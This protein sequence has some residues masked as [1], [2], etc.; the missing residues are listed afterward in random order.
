M[1]FIIMAQGH[2]RWAA[3]QKKKVSEKL[4]GQYTSLRFTL[5]LFFSS[6]L[7]LLVV[8]GLRRCVRKLMD[9][10]YK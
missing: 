3:A 9:V 7:F 6:L 2:F 1:E 5:T 4:L 10:M 8:R